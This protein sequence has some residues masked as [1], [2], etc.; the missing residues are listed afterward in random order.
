MTTPS[1]YKNVNK[2]S[3]KWPPFSHLSFFLFIY[4]VCIWPS[5]YMQHFIPKYKLMI[6]NQLPVTGDNMQKYQ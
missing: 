3:S 4:F 6:S 5:L 1:S 2:M